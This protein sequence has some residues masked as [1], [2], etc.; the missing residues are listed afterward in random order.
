MSSDKVGR[1]L[2][3]AMRYSGKVHTTF[4]LQVANILQ[5]S[6]VLRP[7]FKTRETFQQ[8]KKLADVSADTG[9]CISY[10]IKLFG[11]MRKMT[12]LHME[13]VYASN[14]RNILLELTNFLEV[15]SFFR[16][17]H[18]IVTVFRGTSR[19]RPVVEEVRFVEVQGLRRHLHLIR[20]SREGYIVP[21]GGCKGLTLGSQVCKTPGHN[22]LQHRTHLTL[23]GIKFMR[24]AKT[25]LGGNSE[26]VLGLLEHVNGCKI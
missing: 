8:D 20:G 1:G 15:I 25:K 13:I 22:R 16:V 4:S 6:Q 11:C 21:A 26:K 9:T 10:A 18:I 17:T 14:D 12:Q 24:S 7:R 19:S 23:D 2:M 3:T 5:V